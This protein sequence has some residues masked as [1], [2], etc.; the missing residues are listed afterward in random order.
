MSIDHEILTRVFQPTETQLAK[1]GLLKLG[2][3]LAKQRPQCSLQLYQGG[4]GLPWELRLKVEGFDGFDIEIAKFRDMKV[5]M[6]RHASDAGELGMIPCGEPEGTVDLLDVRF[7][8][9]AAKAIEHVIQRGAF[10]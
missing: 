1:D 4:E 9:S 10:A 7:T 2:E 6:R 5:E 8:P 3:T